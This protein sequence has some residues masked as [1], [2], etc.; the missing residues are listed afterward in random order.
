M[1]S[2]KMNSRYESLKWIYFASKGGFQQVLRIKKDQR[3]ITDNA[4]YRHHNR[5]NR[6]DNRC[7]CHRALLET[8][9]SPRTGL[10]CCVYKNTHREW[11]KFWHNAFVHIAFHIRRKK[12][13]IKGNP[14]IAVAPIIGQTRKRC[15]F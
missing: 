4:Y 3:Y 1:N 13:Q 8:P 2:V 12:W 9:L 10:I 14:W 6:Y 7:F 11:S 15:A 5:R